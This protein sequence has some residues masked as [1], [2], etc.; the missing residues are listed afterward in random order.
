MRRE[1]DNSSFFRKWWLKTSLVEERNKISRSRNLG[2]RQE[3]SKETDIKT[4]YNFIV[5]NKDKEKYLK[6]SKRKTTCYTQ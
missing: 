1:T 2:S 4:R 3:K 5:K 6:S